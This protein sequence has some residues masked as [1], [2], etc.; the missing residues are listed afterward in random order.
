[1]DTNLGLYRYWWILVVLQVVLFLPYM[2]LLHFVSLC[3]CR[4]AEVQWWNYMLLYFQASFWLWVIYLAQCGQCGFYPGRPMIIAAIVCAVLLYLCNLTSFFGRE[5]KAIW[6]RIT[7]DTFRR[8]QSQAMLH[9]PQLQ[10]SGEAFHTETDWQGHGSNRKR[11]TTKI[12]TY[13]GSETLQYGAWMDISHL[14]DMEPLTDNDR[15]IINF[16]FEQ[17]PGDPYTEETVR[18]VKQNYRDFLSKLDV[19]TSE[20]HEKIAALEVVDGEPRG[21]LVWGNEQKY[22]QDIENQIKVEKE[23]EIFSMLIRQRKKMLE[24]KDE[25]EKDGKHYTCLVVSDNDAT[26]PW[27]MNKVLMVILNLLVI[28]VLLK[29]FITCKT[30]KRNFTLTKLYYCDPNQSQ[31]PFHDNRGRV[32]YENLL[33]TQEG[34]VLLSRFNDISKQANCHLVNVAQTRDPQTAQSDSPGISPMYVPPPAVNPNY[35]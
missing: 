12:T 28:S 32:V 11:K 14:P 29:M 24:K 25:D 26:L 22:T 1:M 30:K 21:K 31:P 17:Y 9:P 18:R 8:Y 34:N 20:H 3:R 5:D 13:T 7:M 23:A 10:F 33:P 16:T 27:Y 15:V 2:F 6:N 19:S 4:P 35:Q